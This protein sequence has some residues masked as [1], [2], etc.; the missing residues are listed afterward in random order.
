MRIYKSA[1]ILGLASSGEAAARLLL[2]EGTKV[3]TIDENKTDEIL[4]RAESL[5]KI[6]AFAEIGSS[7]APQG[8]FDVC[9]VSP[10]IKPESPLLKE[11]KARGIP[12]LPEFE[13]GWSRARCPVL[14][15]SGSNG[16]STLVKLCAESLQ[17]SGLTAFPA[18][19]YGP[20][21]SRVV[22][23]HPEA[24]WL[25]IEVSSFQLEEMRKF[26]PQVAVLLNIFP[27]HLDRHHDMRDYTHIKAKLFGRMRENDKAIINENNLDEIRGILAAKLP[28]CSFGLSAKADY[29]FR[30]GKVH[31]SATGR[32]ISFVGTIFDNPVLGQ[33]AAAAAAAMEACGVPLNCLESAAKN[34]QPLPHRCEE[35]GTI[36]RVKFIDDSKSTN[37]AALAAALEMMKAKVHLIAGGLPKNESYRDV[38]QLLKEKA[39]AVYLIGKAAADMEAQWCDVVSCHQCGTLENAVAEAWR[40]AV[41]GDT[42]LLSPACASFDQFRNFEERGRQFRV[43]FNNIIRKPH[44]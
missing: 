28:L 41:P 30:H 34:F 13:L 26:R 23:E 39:K 29:R 17:Q 27:N 8:D 22:L 36:N 9:I 33:T 20:P 40:A 6:G 3:H 15:V 10:G 25:V 37:V 12:V 31:S 38:R 1:L 14:A 2:G 18:G 35:I 19:N 11:V 16:K 21:V 32:K 42:V 44:F 4:G 24:E 7:K 5:E 43:F